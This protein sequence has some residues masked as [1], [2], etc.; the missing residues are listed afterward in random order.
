MS[1]LIYMSVECIICLHVC[2]CSAALMWILNL[3]TAPTWL[4]R[5]LSRLYIHTLYQFSVGNTR[6]ANCGDNL[7]Q[8][9]RTTYHHPAPKRLCTPYW[10]SCTV[11]SYLT[12]AS[13]GNRLIAAQ[14]FA[15]VW[16][17][18]IIY[19]IF[20]SINRTLI[21]KN[22]GGGECRFIL[23]SKCSPLDSVL[24]VSA[25]VLQGPGTPIS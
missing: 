4:G 14:S 2:M 12:V 3:P 19:C 21:P 9:K 25:L 16:T 18:L 23:W 24:P 8:R 17:L 13:F 5:V 22:W 11:R 15:T 20:R 10:R 6:K 1:Q 7:C